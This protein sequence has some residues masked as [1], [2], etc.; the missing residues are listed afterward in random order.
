VVLSRSC[1]SRAKDV[2]DLGVEE[3]PAPPSSSVPDDPAI[4][5]VRIRFLL[6]SYVSKTS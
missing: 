5:R 4:M 3:A 2:K 6:S 1:S